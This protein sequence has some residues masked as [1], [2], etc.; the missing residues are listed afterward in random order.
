MGP[1]V[2]GLMI[3]DLIEEVGEAG[4]KLGLRRQNFVEGVVDGDEEQDGSIRRVH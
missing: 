1:C 3:D 4:S 2:F